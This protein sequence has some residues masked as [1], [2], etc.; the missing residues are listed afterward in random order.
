MGYYKYIFS[1]RKHSLQYGHGQ[2]RMPKPIRIYRRQC[3]R[4]LG[5]LSRKT[6][7]K[8]KEKR[9]KVGDTLIVL[10][11]ELLVQA[12]DE[13]RGEDEPVDHHRT[14]GKSPGHGVGVFVPLIG[15]GGVHSI[16]VLLRLV[17]SLLFK[18]LEKLPWNPFAVSVDE[19][20]FD[21]QLVRVE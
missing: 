5:E 10:V 2:I 19:Q 12:G 17:P 20:V 7:D 1:Y 21:E 8:K 15:N 14:V 3:R 16:E 13:L 4:C 11:L 18:S 9:D 6:T